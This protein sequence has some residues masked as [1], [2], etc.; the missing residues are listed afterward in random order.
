MKTR[1]RLYIHP[2]QR[3]YVFLTFILLLSYTF[4]LAVALFIP[5]ALKLM[6]G[7]PLEEQVLAASQFIALSDRLWPAILVSIPL[8]MVMS[9]WAT[10]KVAGPVYRLERS[11]KQM[12][13]GDIGLK[14]RLRA[15]DELKE[16]AA[17]L[18]RIIER[19]GEAL[20][21]VRSVHQGL[22]GA[23]G[24]VRSRHLT[25]EQVGP[26]LERIQI[27]IEDLESLLRQFKMEPTP[28]APADAAGHTGPSGHESESA[29]G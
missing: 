5:P 28:E 16:L 7:S 8:F 14:I 24:E 17:L 20:Q 12:A 3:K 25:P 18:N 9:L 13:D 1:T 27:Q 11:L 10:H 26:M 15:G 19:Q 29:R 2:I 4:I 21:T 23:M 6:G 22:L